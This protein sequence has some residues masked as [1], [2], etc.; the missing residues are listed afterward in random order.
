[1]RQ[2]RMA[3][4]HVADMLLGQLIV[5]QVQRIEAVPAETGGD[6]LVIRAARDLHAHEDVRHAVVGDA[7]VELGHVARAELLA[8]ALEAAAF[9]GDADRE[10]RFARLA[11]L[12]AL[13]D[14]AQAVEVHVGAA[15]NGYQVLALE[16][17]ALGVELQA[18]HGHGACRLQDA[19]GVLEHVLDA[20]A[21]GVGVHQ[22]DLVDQLARDAKGFLADQL[23]GGAV[24]EQ[25][26]FLEFH[27]LARVH[28][29]LHRVG[30]HGL[31]ANHLDLRAHGL[32]IGRNAGDQ[33]AT[34]DRHEHRVQRS[35]VLAQ[36]FHGDGALA[37]DDFGIVEGV[38]EG[39]LVLFLQLRGVVVGV[40]VRVAVQHDFHPL[41]AALSHRVDL[42]LRGGDRHRDQRLAL[43]PRSR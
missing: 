18:G 21:D 5:G 19:A 35:R 9:L 16:L 20:G 42:H 36:D 25:A 4:D 17:L 29:A 30:V 22:D 6:L 8:E 1:M 41:A 2:R 7:V 11:H 23:H 15:G 10:D 32:D 38:D 31:H 27:A 28:R 39:Q 40:A 33:A 14:K 34:A 3:A 24:R 12:G 37:G 43:E 13:G 26:H